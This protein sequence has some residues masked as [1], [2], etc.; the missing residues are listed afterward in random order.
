MPNDWWHSAVSGAAFAPGFLP[1]ALRASLRLFKIAP[2]N[3]VPELRLLRQVWPRVWTAGVSLAIT[4]QV[5]CVACLAQGRVRQ[6]PAFFSPDFNQGGAIVRRRTPRVPS[7]AMGTSSK[8][9]GAGNGTAEGNRASDRPGIETLRSKVAVLEKS[10]TAQFL[11][12]P[13]MADSGSGDDGH[14]RSVAT[15]VG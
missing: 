5:E 7:S 9:T 11:R 8:L 13:A 15:Q 3:F 10:A 6:R 4:I 2:A 1:Y 14:R 12:I